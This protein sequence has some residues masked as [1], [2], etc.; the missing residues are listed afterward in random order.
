MTGVDKISLNIMVFSVIT[1]L[2]VFL[3]V[4]L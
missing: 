4:L 1:L 2:I 3:L